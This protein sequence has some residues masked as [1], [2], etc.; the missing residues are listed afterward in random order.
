MENMKKQV[1]FFTIAIAFCEVQHE[2]GWWS[3]VQLRVS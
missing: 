2:K 3:A 1:F